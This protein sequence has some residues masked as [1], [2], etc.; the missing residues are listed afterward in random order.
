MRGLLEMLPPP[1]IEKRGWPWTAETDPQ[2]YSCRAHWPMLTIVTP[3]YNQGRFIEE[4]IRSVL[5]QNYPNLEYFVVDGG[6]TDGTLEIIKQYSQWVTEWVSEKDDGQGNAINKGFARGTGDML[7]WLN[8]DDIYYHTALKTMMDEAMCF[9]GHVAYVGSCDKV[10]PEGRSISTVAPRNLHAAGIADWYGSGFFYQPACFFRRSVFEQ[11]GG[12]NEAY[13]NALDIELWMKLAQKGSF[14]KVNSVVAHAKIHH[15]MKTLKCL[16]LRDAE[17]AAVALSFGYP[18]AALRRLNSYAKYYAKN[19]A[20]VG[21]LIRALAGRIWSR[22]RGA[23]WW[24]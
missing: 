9:P 3:S 2:V 5:L 13:Q 11:S 22:A 23:S 8:S 6:S 19:D 21:F 4:T 18:D 16:P 7:A 20:D 24:R 10:D 12:I 14:R 15:D 17:T 1:P